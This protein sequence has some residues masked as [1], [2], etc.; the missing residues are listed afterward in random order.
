MHCG[1]VVIFSFCTLIHQYSLQVG[2]LQHL[3]YRGIM[4]RLFEIS[5]KGKRMQKEK[6]KHLEKDKKVY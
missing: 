5:S 3:G 2:V 1:Y 4:Q 6:M